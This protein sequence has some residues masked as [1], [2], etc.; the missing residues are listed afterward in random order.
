MARKDGKDRGLF[1]RKGHPAWWI[2]WTCP[3]GH[4]HMEKIGPK[5][6]AREM[7]QRRK[8]LVKTADF[9]LTEA[10]EAAVKDTPCLF[11]DLAARY[12]QWCREAR[13]R[14]VGFRVSAMRHLL[15]TFGAQ[16]IRAITR[17][18]VQ[19]Y[20]DVRKRAAT[21]PATVNRE[22]EVLS[23]CF[24][25]AIQWD[26]AA[27]NP[28]QATARLAEV[29]E[30][31]RPLTLEEEARLMAGLPA[32]YLPFVTLALHTG[33]RL[34]ELR[35]QE[36]RD[37]DLARGL[38][39]VTRPKS[40]KREA[41]PLNQAA[42]SVLAALPQD[43]PRLFPGLPVKLSNSFV[44]YALKAGLVDVTFHCLRDTYISRLA[45]QCTTPTLMALARHRDYRTTQRYIRID[46][47]HLRAAVDTLVSVP[48]AAVPLEP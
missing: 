42:F 45:P 41:L 1:Q 19:T 20:I 13:P 25:Q 40:G 8:T 28:V 37:V 34:G 18:Q 26:L 44:R 6:L 30:H 16:D 46:G 31:P 22:R 27:A 38:L 29:N 39:T 35:T 23:H 2:R 9:C 21:S 4:E 48:H 12:L 11:R 7:Y 5:S 43:G 10:R 32:H 17:A 15:E 33:L 14:S 47:A 3:Y 36:W 24:S